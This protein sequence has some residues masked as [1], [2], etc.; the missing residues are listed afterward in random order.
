MTLE[1][2]LKWR[3]DAKDALL[4]IY[5]EEQ[6]DKILYWFDRIKGQDE[7]DMIGNDEVNAFLVF[8][9]AGGKFNLYNSLMSRLFIYAPF[10]LELKD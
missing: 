8:S 10:I 7:R 6:A 2:Y 3:Q 1:E 5:T 4:K 9:S